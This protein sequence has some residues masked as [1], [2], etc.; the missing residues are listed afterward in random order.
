MDASG[1][2]E[3]T[4]PGFVDVNS[5]GNE[6]ASRTQWMEPVNSNSF[7]SGGLSGG[8][9]SPRPS[10]RSVMMGVRLAHPGNAR[11]RSAGRGCQLVRTSSTYGMVANN[12][13]VNSSCSFSNN[14]FV[15]MPALRGEMSRMSSQRGM[16][17][18]K[19]SCALTDGGC[20]NVAGAS[21]AAPS[22]HGVAPYHA[23]TATEFADEPS[24]P[25]QRPCSSGSG[26]P[27]APQPWA[28]AARWN[29][30]RDG[31]TGRRTRSPLAGSRSDSPPKH[32]PRVTTRHQTVIGNCAARRS[33]E[34]PGSCG[35]PGRIGAAPRRM[36]SSGG[37]RISPKAER[38]RA[39]W[40]ASPEPPRACMPEQAF[41]PEQAY[42]NDCATEGVEGGCMNAYPNLMIQNPDGV[43]SVS[44]VEALSRIALAL[45][46]SGNGTLAGEPGAA[47]ATA[48]AAIAASAAAA[49]GT[50]ECGGGFGALNDFNGTVAA[51][52]Q[53]GSS[54]GV[55]TCWRKG[56]AQSLVLMPQ[57]LAD[58][59]ERIEHV[60]QTIKDV[61][62]ESAACG[63]KSFGHDVMSGTPNAVDPGVGINTAANE[64]LLLE[65]LQSRAGRLEYEIA[66]LR[67]QVA[68]RLDAA[69][70]EVAASRQDAEDAR[71]EVASL[72]LEVVKLVAR[73]EHMENTA[74]IPQV[75]M[76]RGD[77][78]QNS[79]KLVPTPRMVSTTAS[80]G[81]NHTN[82]SSS[83][84][85]A[86]R[87]H[88]MPTSLER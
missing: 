4:M 53:S 86:Q 14:S 45:E 13:S 56:A 60:E 54:N 55:D 17:P 1:S 34:S 2:V 47:V 29:T 35:I 28:H 58:L 32:D 39:D 11:P 68:R 74:A 31:L 27:R 33:G 50:G 71:A 57:V 42:G 15:A 23:M 19:S 43:H 79:T 37:R 48:V 36:I 76:H 64:R 30:E 65:A 3:S 44:L 87:G 6:P 88:N 18:C 12:S 69:A 5:G 51:V 81:A 41:M 52:P 61:H 78:V 72:R 20:S 83:L 10:G 22:G 25:G 59:E 49:A 66:G 46:R 21:P 38:S 85:R 40:S 75:S 9:G 82:G 24:Q 16:Q 26:S 8:T 63:A 84:P 70:H 73:L 7:A 62:L 80:R 67:A 77:T